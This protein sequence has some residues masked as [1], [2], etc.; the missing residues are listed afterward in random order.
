M[1]ISSDLINK[2]SLVVSGH[3]DKT[4]K[5]HDWR[6]EQKVLEIETSHSEPITSVD[7]SFDK[8]MLVTNSRDNT[9]QVFDT[10]SNRVMKI[11]THPQYCCSTEYLTKAYFK[12][13]TN[14]VIAVPSCVNSFSENSANGIF[15]FNTNS[16]SF[17]LIAHQCRVNDI[18]F[19]NNGSLIGATTGKLEIFKQE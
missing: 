9:L 4:L 12:P 11:L 18:A 1:Y 8:N 16:N 10:R 15:I 17:E 6:Q 14:D 3:F 5:F 19:S 7:V 13:N 2:Y